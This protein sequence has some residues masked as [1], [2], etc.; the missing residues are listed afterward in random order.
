M[1]NALVELWWLLKHGRG[2]REVRRTERHPRLG[3]LT[4][5][6]RRVRPGGHLSGMWKLKPEGFSRAFGV[7]FPSEGNE[8]T[9]EGLAQLERLLADLD[10]LFD[11]ARSQVREQ[12][13]LTVERPMPSEWREAFE[14][15]HIELPDPDTIEPEWQMAYWCEAALHWFVVAFHG[16][17][18]TYVQM[19][20]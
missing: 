19:D 20:G 8:P 14:L 5:I 15:D 7:D 1:A 4:Y 11:R 6:G 18:V 3:E 2:W 13:E 10:Q 17:V 9:P 16:D 12:F